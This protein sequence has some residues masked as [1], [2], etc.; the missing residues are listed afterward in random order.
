MKLLILLLSDGNDD[1][2]GGNDGNYDNGEKVVETMEMQ[3]AGGNDGNDD[4][5]GN[6]D[7]DNSDGNDDGD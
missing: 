3:L 5:D 7:N 1:C 6:H 4:S 2:S